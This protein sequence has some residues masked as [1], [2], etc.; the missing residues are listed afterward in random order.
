M[1]HIHEITIGFYKMEHS[2]IKE[3]L[4]EIKNMEE[5]LIKFDKYIQ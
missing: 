3:V 5:D 1:D 4:L 2:K